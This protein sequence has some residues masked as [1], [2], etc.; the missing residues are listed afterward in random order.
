M[1]PTSASPARVHP[2]KIGWLGTAALAMGGSNQMVFLIGALVAGQGSI[3]GQGT[4]AVPLLV[5]VVPVM[6]FL[7][8]LTRW[9]VRSRIYR[10]YGELKYI[11]DDLARVERNGPFP[12]TVVDSS[13]AQR[14]SIFSIAP[15]EAPSSH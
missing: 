11:E 15:A 3:P 13:P 1:T 5:V 14:T 7:P 12:V 6:R 8:A 10:W 2:R 9:H 4:A